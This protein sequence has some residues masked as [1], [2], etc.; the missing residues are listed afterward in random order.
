[1]QIQ[2]KI[3]NKNIRKNMCEEYIYFTCKNI[4]TELNKEGVEKKRLIGMPAEWNTNINKDNYKN[5]ITDGHKGFCVPAGKINN[6]TVI[7]FD[8]KEGYEEVLLIHP[9][10]KNYKTVETRRGYHVYC[11][12]NDKLHTL[13]DALKSIKGVDIAND[14]HMILSPPTSYYTLDGKLNKYVDLGGELYDVPDFIIKDYKYKNDKTIKQIIKK[15][16]NDIVIDKKEIT[17]EKQ[18]LENLSSI[19]NK[20]PTNYFNTYENWLNLCFIIYNETNGSLNGYNLFN[21]T[22][23][24]LSGYDE[25]QCFKQY[26]NYNKKNKMKIEKLKAMLRAINNDND[27]VDFIAENDNEAGKM[28]FEDLK[29]IIFSYNGTYFYKNSNIWTN[30]QK[31]IDILILKYIQN[32]N[33][34]KIVQLKDNQKLVDYSASIT[35]A[36]KIKESFYG[37]IIQDSMVYNNENEK[38]DKF[39]STTKDRLA[40]ID[41]VLDLKQKKF[42]KWESINFEY[43]STNI[44]QRC[45]E[46]YFNNPNIT[47]IDEIKTQ[48]IENMFGDQTNIALQFL[49]RGICGHIEDKK[50]SLYMGNRNCGK[51]V[52]YDALSSAFGSYIKPF[53]LSNILYSRNTSGSETADPSKKLGWLIN[54]EFCRIGISQEVPDINSGLKCNGSLLK[55]MSG[56]GDK[57]TARKLFKDDVQINIDTTWMILG[58]NSLEIDTNDA[59]ETCVQFS[60]V[61]Q[62]KT[63]EEIEIYKKELDELELKRYKKKDAT[64]KDKV[65]TVEWSNAFVYLLMDNYNEKEVYIK[66]EETDSDEGVSIL[67][68]IKDN[69]NITYN[70]EHIIKCNDIYEALGLKDKKKITAE[71]N[72]INIFKTKCKKIGEFRDKWIFTGIERKVDSENEQIEIINI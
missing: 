10:M 50:W 69:F 26:N 15:E 16:N 5:Y 28:I 7:D 39:H 71:L 27:I 72:S 66:K 59:W 12:Y 58:N 53:D 63:E 41:G 40:F 49:S 17:N 6:I 43:Y 11:N 34:K 57:I 48:L 42:Y 19:I 44:I 31:V 2:N 14:G 61:N 33:I 37:E 4:R 45:F 29:D 56:G 64:I 32:K 20:F 3:E 47:I 62:F 30:D 35:N 54:F 51:G 18:I 13:T 65:K 23:K 8:N 9:E 22:C 46:P 70:N 52:L 55:K 1:M 38:Y 68:L 25:N 21:D 24:K 60:S 36:T 67:K